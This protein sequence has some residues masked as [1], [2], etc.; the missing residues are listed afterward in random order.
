FLCMDRQGSKGPRRGVV[1]LAALIA[2][3]MALGAGVAAADGPG[4]PVSPDTNTPYTPTPQPYDEQT[5]PWQYIAGQRFDSG[6]VSAITLRDV[7]F[8]SVA[9]VKQEL[10]FAGGSVCGD[11]TPWDTPQTC[12]QPK[13]A[14][15][16]YDEHADG[17]YTWAPDPT[18]PGGGT[19]FVGAIA[20][21][22]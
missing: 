6:K 18:F 14:L 20:V 4:L 10:G 3:T 5:S 12:A 17:T 13:P 2:V 11:K 7:N 1:R 19:G 8:S 16:R 9:F 15:W 21:I 22:P